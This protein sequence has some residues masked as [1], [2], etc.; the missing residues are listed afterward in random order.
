MRPDTP[1]RKHI[2]H[3]ITD[4]PCVWEVQREQTRELILVLEDACLLAREAGSSQA[5]AIEE[6]ARKLRAEEAQL[7]KIIR[8]EG[9]DAHDMEA[10]ASHAEDVRI[11]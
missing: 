7:T 2:D 6:A 3:D 8:E 9:G 4:C 5:A 10:E 1:C 11:P